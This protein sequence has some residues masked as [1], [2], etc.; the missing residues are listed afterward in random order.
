MAS[1]RS[2]ASL[3][4]SLKEDPLPLPPAQWPASLTPGLP[5]ALLFLLLFLLRLAGSISDPEDPI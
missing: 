4:A 5:L 2:L 1:G 3:L